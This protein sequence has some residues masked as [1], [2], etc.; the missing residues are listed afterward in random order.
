MTIEDYRKNELTNQASSG[1]VFT[2]V[3][4]IHDWH[5]NELSSLSIRDLKDRWTW[6]KSRVHRQKNNIIARALLLDQKKETPTVIESLK[7]EIAA[8][9]KLVTGQNGTASGTVNSPTEQTKSDVRK[10]AGQNGTASGTNTLSANDQKEKE[11]KEKRT[12][13]E[14]EQREKPTPSKENPL[15]GSKESSPPSTEPVNIPKPAKR[16]KRPDLE[17]AVAY[18]RE[19]CSK[20]KI[21]LDAQTE[22]EAWYDHKLSNGW[23]VGKNPMKDWKATVRTWIRLRNQPQARN[24]YRSKSSNKPEPKQRTYHEPDYAHLLRA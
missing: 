4:A 20:N 2:M 1:H 5:L 11:E 21:T 24:N 13:K 10:A 15:K 3:D 12:K 23:K 18:F 17:E 6:S 7:R 8:L 14:K 19:Y 9:A 16:M 22:A